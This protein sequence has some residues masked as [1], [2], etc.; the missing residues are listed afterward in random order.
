LQGVEAVGECCWCSLNKH[1]P[2]FFLGH[3]LDY[4]GVSKLVQCKRTFDDSR[5]GRPCLYVQWL[6]WRSDLECRWCAN[7]SAVTTWIYG[8]WIT[9]FTWLAFMLFTWEKLIKKTSFKIIILNSVVTTWDYS[10]NCCN[11]SNV[12]FAVENC[13]WELK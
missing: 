4:V 12:L 13:V 1:S 5:W 7:V 8:Q 2:R 11:A 6:N 9:K 10:F 3:W